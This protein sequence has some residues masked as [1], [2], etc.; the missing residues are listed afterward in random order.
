MADHSGLEAAVQRH[1]SLMERMMVLMKGHIAHLCRQQDLTPPQL[2]ALQNIEGAG[3]LKVSPLA[4][5]LGLSMGATSTLV[6]RLVA[7][8]L[9]TRRQDPEDRRAVF[10]SITDKGAQA[11][12]MVRQSRRALFSS[13]LG[14]MDAPHRE[15]LLQG[16]EQMVVATERFVG[17]PVELAV[18][19]LCPV[20]GGED[21]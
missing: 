10:V 12:A 6:D 9:V 5:C 1:E 14:S 2:W 15:A 8:D 21:S 7:R 19:G 18:G 16:F 20:L 11:V 3:S 4:A 17:P 13:I